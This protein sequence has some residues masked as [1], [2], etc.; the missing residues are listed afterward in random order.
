MA[1]EIPQRLALYDLGTARKLSNKLGISR[2]WARQI[3]CG[4]MTVPMAKRLAKIIKL[5]WHVIHDWRGTK[6]NGK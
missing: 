5:P 1:N 4:H 2:Q 3:I 6:Q